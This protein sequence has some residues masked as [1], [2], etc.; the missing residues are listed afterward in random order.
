MKLLK[1]SAVCTAALLAACGGGGDDVATPPLPE[2]V[3]TAAPEADVT[4]TQDASLIN[5]T[6]GETVRV[7]SLAITCKQDK[8]AAGGTDPWCRDQVPLGDIGIYSSIDLRNIKVLIDGQELDGWV[9]KEQNDLYRFRS[10]WSYPIY[11]VGN[12]E[13]V[14]TISPEAASGQHSLVVFKADDVS[15]DKTLVVVPAQAR[16]QVNAL[17]QYAPM[18]LTASAGMVVYRGELGESAQKSVDIT[19]ECAEGTTCY[20][21]VSFGEVVGLVPGTLVELCYSDVGGETSCWVTAEANTDGQ[22]FIGTVWVNDDQH[23]Q[24]RV[25]PKE[26]VNLYASAVKGTVG[27]KEIAPKLPNTCSAVTRDR[28]PG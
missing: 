15:F 27:G 19:A 22:A 28:C 6:P 16:L 2:P 20:A 11:Q 23:V 1:I 5:V 17:T 8:T 9:T 26:A 7:T 24:L 21:E 25:Y 12:M 10:Q 13:I 14:A 4:L 3:V 18:T